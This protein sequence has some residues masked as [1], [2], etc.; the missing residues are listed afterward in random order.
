MA[1]YRKY[2]SEPMETLSPDGFYEAQ[3]RALLKE[4]NYVWQNSLFYQEKF[5]RAGIEL[6]DIKGARRFEQAPV[7]GEERAKGESGFISSAGQA[8]GH[9]TG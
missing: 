7:H 1:E 6:G 8:R 9:R 2:W 3:T 4:L 5:Q